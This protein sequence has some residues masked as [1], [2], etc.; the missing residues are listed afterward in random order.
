MSRQRQNIGKKG[1]EIAR[2]YLEKNGYEIIT[3]NYRTKYGE[4][5]LIARDGKTLVFIEVKTRTQIKF[6]SPF[7]AL[8]E[9]KRL[10][11]SRVA[12]HYLMTH[13]GT[14]QPSRFDVVA[15]RPGEDVEVEIVRNAFDFRFC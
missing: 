10:N 6:G 2:S 4:I 8:T 11:I 12:L 7:D 15:V 9:S 3:A 13:G 14:E 1:E 5:D